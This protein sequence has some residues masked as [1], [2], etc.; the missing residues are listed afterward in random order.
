MT[1]TSLTT[2]TT[3]PMARTFTDEQVSLIKRQIAKGAT[4]DELA[5]FLAQCSRTGLDPFSRQIYAIK[6]WDNKEGREV[7]GVQ[8]SIDGL[9]LIA[10]R[11]GRY[12]G[13][14]G[15]HWCGKDGAWVD[16]WLKDEPP[17]AARVGVYRVGFQ[18]PLYAVARWGSYAQMT[19]DGRLMGL[20]S[21]MP[22]LMIAKCA[23]A[24]ALRKAFPQETSGL[25]TTEEMA[26]AGGTPVAQDSERTVLLDYLRGLANDARALGI[27]VPTTKP[28]EYT[29]EQLRTLA[30]ALEAQIEA[31]QAQAPKL[32]SA[33]DEYDAIEG[34]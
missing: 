20:W 12:A 34:K 16:V 8:V 18:A 27:Q 26:Q 17:A 24:L 10:E 1:S 14:D 33:E 11:T 3:A 23:E 19:R 9:R 5:L 15:P 31:A 22:D 6:R 13:Q 2:Y 28:S 21:K 30:D 32:P 29:T 4:D 7:M 25:Y